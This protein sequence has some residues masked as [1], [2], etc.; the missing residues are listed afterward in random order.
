MILRLVVHPRMEGRLNMAVDE[1]LAESAGSG[2]GPVVRLYGFN[3]PTLSLGRFQRVLGSL[4]QEALAADGV[5]LARRPTGGHAVLHD[6]ELTY[7]VAFS[8]VDARE[9]AGSDGK[10]AV[11]RFIAKLLLEGLAKLGI[12]AKLVA[13]GSGDPRNPDCFGSAGEYEIA[14][15]SGAKLIGSAQAVTRRWILQHGSIPIDNPGGRVLRWLRGEPLRGE[16]LGA[17]EPGEHPLD[18]VAP[19]PSCLGE[20]AGRALSF[21]EVERAFAAA[22]RS[23]LAAADAPLAPREERRAR[24]LL[25]TK[26]AIDGWNLRC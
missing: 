19:R 12:K 9:L 11:Y 2:A 5:T 10:R 25:A 15:E 22:A 24:D 13:T 7:A 20:Q 1:A 8:R 26:Y 23:V 17:G 3:P 18:P 6:N 4:D 16:R 14:A 21:E